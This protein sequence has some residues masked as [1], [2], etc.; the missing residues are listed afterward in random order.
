MDLRNKAQWHLSINNGFVP[1]LETPSG[2]IIYESA[3]IADFASNVA[4]GSGLA[5]WPHE[6]AGRQGEQEAAI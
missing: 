3:L 2:A 1:V 6:V 5:L 4:A